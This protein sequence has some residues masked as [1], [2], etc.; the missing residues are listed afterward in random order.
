MD[1]LFAILGLLATTA[2]FVVM[3][4]PLIRMLRLDQVT[5]TPPD[6]AF[7]D[8]PSRRR[9][10]M[11]LFQIGLVIWMAVAIHEPNT[12]PTNDVIVGIFITWIATVL[13]VQIVHGLRRWLLRPLLLRIDKPVVGKLADRE[14][15]RDRGGD[16]TVRLVG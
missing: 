8:D 14:I 10:P 5:A 11:R 4:V 9:W 6:L 3:T 13:P 1:V 7:V 15:G 2:V 16:R 12:D